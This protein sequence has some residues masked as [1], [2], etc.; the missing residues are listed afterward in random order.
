MT[1]ES[2]LS[3]LDKIRD[4][5]R[6]IADLH[7]TKR[8]ASAMKQELHRRMFEE[9]KTTFSRISLVAL[10][11]IALLGLNTINF[12]PRRAFG[13]AI[14][15]KDGYHYLN[16]EKISIREQELN[17]PKEAIIAKDISG[18]T[19]S[20]D[21]VEEGFCQRSPGD[22]V[23]KS[24]IKQAVAYVPGTPDS[25][26]ITG[27]CTLCRDN[28]FSPS[29]AVGRGA[30][31][32]HSGVAAYNVASYRTT[33]GTPA[34]EAQPAEYSYAPSSYTDSPDYSKPPVPSIETIVGY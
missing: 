5:R 14:W 11:L 26:V 28:T 6:Q 22:Y 7:R 27:Y 10:V 20:C 34:V 8:T 33:P 18:S 17:A 25:R 15:I 13:G 30:C 4:S 23:K 29:C 21:G 3:A 2:K 31:S 1:H 32:Y 24:L 9:Y 16:N 19:P 12:A